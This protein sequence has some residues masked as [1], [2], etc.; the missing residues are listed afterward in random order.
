M[1]KDLYKNNKHTR[2]SAPIVVDRFYINDIPVCMSWYGC[3]KHPREAC[4]FLLARRFGTIPVC[5]LTGEDMR[6]EADVINRVP[7]DC[8]LHKEVV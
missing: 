4:R 1:S 5:G 8:P 7:D 3:D 2:D 6:T